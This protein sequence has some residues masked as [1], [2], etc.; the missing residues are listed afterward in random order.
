MTSSQSRPEP[1]ICAYRD[2]RLDLLLNR[3]SRIRKSGL[4]PEALLVVDVEVIEQRALHGIDPDLLALTREPFALVRLVVRPG[5]F[6]AGGP[7]LDLRVGLRCAMAVEP[8]QHFVIA[9][10]RRQ[11]LADFVA[12][13]ALETEEHVIEW[14]VEMIFAVRAV[15]GRPALVDHPRHDHISANPLFRAARG[16]LG[17]VLCICELC[18]SRHGLRMSVA[19]PQAQM[20]KA[21]AAAELSRGI[22]PVMAPKEVTRQIELG[23]S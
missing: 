11:E 21:R 22:F 19:H 20:P 8:R 4:L 14:A 23:L 2:F 10:A 1:S 6:G 7:C 9:R 5:G 15:E 12:F 17:Q 18:R 3:K 13:H 16:F